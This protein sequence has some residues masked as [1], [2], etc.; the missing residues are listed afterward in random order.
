MATFKSPLQQRTNT[1]IREILL[2]FFYLRNAGATCAPAEQRYR[3]RCLVGGQ[4]Y[5]SCWRVRRRCTTRKPLHR[6]ISYIEKTMYTRRILCLA[7]SKKPPSGRCIAGKAMAHN[8]T[9]EWIRPV[10][11]RPGHE[12]SEDERRYEDG[13]T[14]QLLDIVDIHFLKSAPALHQTENR[15]IAGDYYWSKAGVANWRQVQGA[16]DDVPAALWLNGVSTQHGQN[17]KVPESELAGLEDSLK[18]VAVARLT[19]N[20]ALEAGFEGRPGRRRVRAAFDVNGQPYVLSVTD[21][22]IEREYLA[23]A[24]GSYR[25]RSAILCISLAEPFYGYAFKV[26]AAVITQSRCRP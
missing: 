13:T 20:V 7:N 21:P 14:A 15:L 2:G 9:G 10:S 25:L 26:V 16:V 23:K 24:D 22:V 18:L 6:S 19:L 12:I 17:D 11:D 4:R 3:F 5:R 8:Q 1:Q